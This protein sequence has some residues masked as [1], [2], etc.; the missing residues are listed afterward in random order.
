MVDRQFSIDKRTTGAVAP[1]PPTPGPKWIA[2]EE[3]ESHQES[4]KVVSV[5]RV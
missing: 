1:V 3:D 4:S 5:V 2:A